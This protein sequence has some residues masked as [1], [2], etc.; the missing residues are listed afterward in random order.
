M[1][2]M[3]AAHFDAHFAGCEIEFVVKHRNLERPQFIKPH[4]GSKRAPGFVHEG[5]WLQQKHFFAVNHPF[6]H[7]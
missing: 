6:R 7:V 1:A 5:F 4:S 3:P 2:G